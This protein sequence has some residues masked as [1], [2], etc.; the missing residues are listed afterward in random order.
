VITL[1]GSIDELA[2]RG[3]TEHFRV[4]GDTLQAID[5]GKIFRAGDVVIREHHRF[6]GVSDPDDRA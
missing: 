3:Y 2:R 6:E 4:R 5:T 1:A